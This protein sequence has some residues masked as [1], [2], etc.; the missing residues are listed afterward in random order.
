MF[1]TVVITLMS[2]SKTLKAETAYNHTAAIHFS[3]AN[4]LIQEGKMEEAEKEL[5]LAVQ[6]D[7]NSDYL[8]IKLSDVLFKLEKYRDVIELLGPAKEGKEGIAP[9][10]YLGLAYQYEGNIEKSNEVFDYIYRSEVAT[11]EDLI[12]VGKILSYEEKFHDAI[13]YYEK[14]GELRPGDADLHTLMGEAYIGLEDA[15]SAKREY[16]KAGESEPRRVKAW[17]VLAQ[18]AENEE[19]WEEALEYYGKVLGLARHPSS[20]L[21]DILRVSNRIGD[22]GRAIGISEELVKKSPESGSLW[23]MLG[24]LYYQAGSLEE[25]N[26]AFLTAIDKGVDSF[27]LYLT[28]GRSLMELGKTEDAIENLEKAVSH[29]PDEFVGWINLALA[30]FALGKYEK[31]MENLEKAEELQP[32]SGQAFYLRGVIL[33]RQERFVE[34]IEPLEKALSASPD[35]KDVILSLAVAYERTQQRGKAEKL[36]EDV[37]LIDPDDHEALNYLGYMWA[38]KGERLDEAEK[39]IGRALELDPENGYYID[40]MA[41][42]YYQKGLYQKALEEMLRSVELVQDDPV[43]LEHLGD[44][45]QKL[46]HIEESHEAWEKSLE[47]DPENEDLREKLEKVHL[48]Q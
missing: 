25:A 40:S 4:I 5:R 32:D 26:K 47:I 3:R 33:S 13:R 31:A 19:S 23:G 37:L 36:L 15:E 38:E 17:L 14:A 29:K 18:L 28:L 24:V 8:K 30:Y 41:W 21:Q 43:I 45:Y 46:G 48:K 1:V 9:Y 2:L 10:L 27:Q 34:A 16:E 39:M 6:E 12:H 44:I 7:P 42:V 11:A 22:Y 20:L 35:N